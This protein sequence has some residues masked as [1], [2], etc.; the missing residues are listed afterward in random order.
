[1]KF[2]FRKI[3]ALALPVL[4]WFAWAFELS[5]Q[6]QLCRF[7]YRNSPG[8]EITVYST[9]G[10]IPNG[11]YMPARVT[12][13]NGS[14]KPKDWNLRFT[15]QDSSYN[16]NLLLN[17]G[18]SLRCGAKSEVTHEILVPLSTVL[19]GDTFSHQIRIEISAPG[20]ESNSARHNGQ[21]S[22]DW[23]CIGI[24]EDLAAHNLRNLDEKV[25][26]SFEKSSRS[27]YANEHF[28]LDFKASQLP[29]DWRGLSALDA[30]MI[31]GK[32][33][34]LLSPGSRQAVLQ[35]NRMGG[36]L[37]IC[38]TDNKATLKELG[39]EGPDAVVASHANAI[40]VLEH[41]ARSLGVVQLNL[42]DGTEL[43]VTHTY[44]TFKPISR[45]AL[46]FI[47][48]YVSKWNLMEEFGSKSFNRWLVLTVLLLFGILVGPVNLWVLA[49]PGKRHLL[50]VTTPILSLGASILMSLMIWFSDGIGGKG[51]R[52]TI[53]NLEP[54]ASERKAYLFQEQ[55]ARTG[56]L[57]GRGFEFKDE[58]T[59]SPVN[60]PTSPWSLFDKSTSRKNS[61]RIHGNRYNGDW[62]RSRCEVGH[63][64]EAVRTTRS[65]IEK[66]ANSDSAAPRL[67]SSLGFDIDLLYYI[68]ESGAVW[69]STAP[70]STGSEI[71]LANSDKT[72]LDSWWEEHSS[73]G[74]NPLRS[75]LMRL[76]AQKDLFFAVTQDPRVD[77][78][79]SGDFIRWKS[80]PVL[81]FGHLMEVA[82]PL[83]PQ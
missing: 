76:T 59:M 42:W 45:K 78:L 70:V 55:I 21:F 7:D 15:S 6:E 83:P 72:E 74:S 48:D 8:T 23:P 73:P 79:A 54:E 60:L 47:R 43:N 63:V 17:S 4:L 61:L 40:P 57:L 14:E 16:E 18:F 37:H 32:E 9:F 28:G 53:L 38:T 58:V 3:N 39:I 71:A 34:R 44:I 69:K 5:A 64:L 41:K 22:K 49:R 29:E 11:G 12:I 2:F 27:G 35:W 33:W 65:R 77:P 31:T 46:S 52:F 56:L 67:F 13:K 20:L 68:D 51:L 66:V 1:M 24:S 36:R 82:S 81:V 62:F 25:K 26:E 30:L 10:R 50:F 75:K 19:D 80:T